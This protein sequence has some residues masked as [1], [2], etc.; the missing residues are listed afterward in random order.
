MINTIFITPLILLQILLNNPKS[1][2]I[3]CLILP[4]RKIIDS[5]ILLKLTCNGFRPVEVL[6]KMS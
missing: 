5:S 2:N 4:S 1:N 3:K 6:Y